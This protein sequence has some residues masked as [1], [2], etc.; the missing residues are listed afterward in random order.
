MEFHGFAADGTALYHASSRTLVLADLHLGFAAARRAR[1]L[2]LPEEQLSLLEEDLLRLFAKY[3]VRRVLFLGDI[4]HEFGRISHE[5]W[6]GVK[7]LLTILGDREPV[8]LAGNHDALL[9][10]ILLRHGLALQQRFRME[11]DRKEILFMHGHE[12]VG[13]SSDLLVMGHEHPAVQISDGL[14]TEMAKCFLVGRR[15]EQ[16]VIVLPAWNPLVTGV[17]VLEERPLGPL[18]TSFNDFSAFAVVGD[19]VLAFGRVERLRRLS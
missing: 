5:E 19:Q 2:L 15:E 3:V 1:G 6:R 9:A 7:R 8:F 11:A 17:N 4:K 14:R 12:Q 16:E 10:P 13:T 18:L